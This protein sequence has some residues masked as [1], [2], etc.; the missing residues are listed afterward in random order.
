MEVPAMPPESKWQRQL[1]V[2][3]DNC[4]LSS[5][6]PQR[7]MKGR[8][9]MGLV[10]PLGFQRSAARPRTHAS[11]TRDCSTTQ[12]HR[13]AA[14]CHHRGGSSG[15][16]RR[17]SPHPDRSRQA[18]SRSPARHAERKGLALRFQ[19]LGRNVLAH[20]APPAA[21]REPSPQRYR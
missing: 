8:I 1:A 18:S 12:H 10:S 6:A 21:T 16:H 17:S 14:P 19:S 4:W 13:C 3:T 9:E 20:G 2:Q 11:G 7:Q 15:S 5:F